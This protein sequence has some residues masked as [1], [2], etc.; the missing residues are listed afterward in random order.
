MGRRSTSEGNF[1]EGYHSPD[2][3]IQ[4]VSRGELREPKRRRAAKQAA[5]RVLATQVQM[6]QVHPLLWQYLRE[7]A[8]KTEGGHIDKRFLRFEPENH[9]TPDSETIDSVIIYD[10]PEQKQAA[11]SE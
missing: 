2:E 7:N 4:E 1:A 10:T 3:T 6:S 11:D 9:V 8:P 5:R